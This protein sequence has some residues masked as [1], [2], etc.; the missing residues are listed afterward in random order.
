MDEAIR[1][2][3]RKI[4]GCEGCARRR[5]KIKK[6]ARSFLKPQNN[7]AVMFSG[8]LDSAYCAYKLRDAGHKV[9]L[10][11]VTWTYSS[12]SN[13][14]EL[15]AARAI[16]ERLELPLIELS[17]VIV[18]LAQTGDIMR[19]PTIGA[20]MICHRKMK[21]EK[22]AIGIAPSLN[23]RDYGWSQALDAL[24]ASCMPDLEIIYPRDNMTR[25]QVKEATPDWLQG[26]TY[27]RYE[28]AENE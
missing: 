14:P 18:P 26:L 25:S 17:E 2:Q 6:A 4:L 24:K 27:S 22:L 12:G 15:L 16:A 13:T 7:V 20:M 21:F 10:V 11:H 5:A 9:E 8:G 28:K 19:V 1:E 23:E 3:W